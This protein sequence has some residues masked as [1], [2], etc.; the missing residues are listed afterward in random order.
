MQQIQFRVTNTAAQASLL[1]EV[2]MHR[3]YAILIVGVALAIGP[4]ANAQFGARYDSRAVTDLVDRVHTDLER[5]YGVHHFSGDDRGRLNHAEKELREFAQ[6][7]DRGKF[8]KGQLDDAISAIQ[9]AL[10]NNK[11]PPNAR[12]AISY[13]VSQLRGMREAY[14]RREIE[15]TR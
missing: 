8:D 14:D 9:H 11:M 3:L 6:K 1:V 5:A 15:G 13:D 4:V 7:W 12:D 10:D 2:T